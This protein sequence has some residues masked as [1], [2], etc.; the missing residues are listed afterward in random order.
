MSLSCCSLYDS[1]FY[2]KYSSNVAPNP[3]EGLKGKKNERK[4]LLD[5]LST[6]WTYKNIELDYSS[7]NIADKIG[8]AYESKSE[9]NDREP[10]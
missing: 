2:L 4:I 6:F 3:G 9:Q 1:E 8:V 10:E 7:L 5:N